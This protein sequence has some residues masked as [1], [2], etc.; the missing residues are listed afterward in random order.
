MRAMLGLGSNLGDRRRYLRDAVDELGADV[1]HVSPVY[2]T[3]PVGGP[4]DQQPYLNLVVEL[5]TGRT[6]R[7]LLVLCHRLEAEAARVRSIRWGP[8]TLDVDVLWC[9]GVDIDE[10]DLQ[11]PHPR[12]AERRFVMAPLRDVAPDLVPDDWEERA[13]GQVTL[14]GE[15]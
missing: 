3:A 13:D 4:P 15:L 10:P 1:V 7:E 14:L 9:D 6:A 8:R 2:E 12:M 5:R 11:V